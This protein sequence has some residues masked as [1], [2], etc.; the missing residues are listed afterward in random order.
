MDR[1]A[2]PGRHLSMTDPRHTIA[3]RNGRR[4]SWSGPGE[5]E[6]QV[7]AHTQGMT[8][9]PTDNQR[10][11]EAR[12]GA[13]Q[14]LSDLLVTGPL[15]TPEEVAAILRVSP[16]TLADWRAGRA[17][18]D[19]PLA[20]RVGGRTVYALRDVNAYLERRVQAAQTRREAGA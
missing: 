8:K 4:G 12:S 13:D 15:C 20:I 5:H 16:R 7:P 9:K 14:R 3:V 18:D 6:L 1:P 2:A 10:P 17:G 11:T 19:T